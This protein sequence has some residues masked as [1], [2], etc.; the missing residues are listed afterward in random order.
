MTARDDLAL[1]G[2][3][4]VRTQPLDTS[5][6]VGV[7]GDEEIEAAIGVLQ[8]R[9]LFR[10]Y[11]PDFKEHANRLEAALQQRFGV[12]HALAVSSG[13]AALQL[14]L[15]GLGVEE[16][17]EIIV[18]A[19]TFI[20]TVGAVV[21]ARAVPVFAEVDESLNLDP[22]SF[23]ANITEKTRAVIPVHLSNAAADMDPIM[24][25][26]RRRK[27]RVLEDAAQAIG[28]TYRGRPVGTIGDAGAFSLQLEKN[29]TSGEGGI[30]L[31]DSFDMY[32]RAVRYHDQGG[33][34]TTSRGG[35]REHTSGE[36]FIGVNLRITELAAA[37]AAVQLGRLD[38]IIERSRVNAAA[39]RQ[40]LGDLPVDWRVLP[41]ESGEGGSVT[42]FLE[43]PETAKEF[44]KAVR[45]EGVPAGQMYG[46]KTVYMNPAILAQRT[47]WS[48]GCPFHC[49]EHPTTRR[50]YEG[51]CPRSEDLLLRSLTVPVGP[52][53]TASDVDDIVTAVRKVSSALL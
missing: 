52:S 12:S 25:I 53:L 11:G 8:S 35:V 17:D 2:G 46:G 5:H 24:E 21:S 34:F 4:P 23:E 37:I 40:R 38:Q 49:K 48:S 16:G 1:N 41:D 27:I 14:G 30:L 7:I 42:M 9:S 43:S 22:A 18:P 19:V 20:A 15:V 10:Y 39:V 26:A 28:V 6:G 45:A 32:D 36:P 47:A 13:T 33:Q 51:L 29:I 31:T 3:T 50:Y 44:G